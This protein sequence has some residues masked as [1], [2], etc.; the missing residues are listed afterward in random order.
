MREKYFPILFANSPYAVRMP[1][2][3]KKNLDSFKHEDLLRFYRKWYRPE[4]M[5]IIAVGDFDKDR[6]EQ[7]IKTHFSGLK[8]N[9][10]TPRLLAPVPDHDSTRIAIT[11]DKE[12]TIATGQRL[13][14][15]AVVRGAYGW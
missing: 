11:T 15:P 2:G 8:S 6:V 12:A 14:S 9:D 5:G 1:I 10:T 4:L 13:Q 3:T 7:L